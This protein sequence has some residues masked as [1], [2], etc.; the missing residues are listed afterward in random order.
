[1]EID[2]LLDFFRT[3]RS[4][5]RFKPD[6]IPDEYIEKMIEAARW[7]PSGANGQPWEFIII[8]DQKTKDRMAE[9]YLQ[10]RQEY[11]AIERTR[12]EDLRH[13]QTA[14]PLEESPGWKDAPVLIVVCGD[15]RTYQ[16]SVLGGRFI[17]GE[18]GLD[19]T[20]QKNIGNA[21]YGIHLAAKA[22]GLGAQWLTVQG[23]WEQL[24]K[25]LL[26]VPPVI[27]IHTIGPGEDPT[28]EPLPPYR[29]R[30]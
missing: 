24:L 9:L 14:N 3:R 25:P 2:E 1:M 30:I 27:M 23:D 29:G 12:V 4:M 7:A 21:T 10:I 28:Y 26:N 18:G 16:A 8:K 6:P 17:G 11:Y 15:R 19:G 20:Y 13:F 5:R 22:L